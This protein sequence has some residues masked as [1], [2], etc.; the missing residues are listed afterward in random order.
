MAAL[1]RTT[2]TAAMLI[3]LP[4]ASAN[5]DLA[6]ADAAIAAKDYGAAIAALQ[7]VVAEIFAISRFDKVLPVHADIA[8]ALADLSPAAHAAWRAAA[9]AP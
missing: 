1:F 9:A 7:P 2:L 3:C 5:A 6:G 8:A 4:L